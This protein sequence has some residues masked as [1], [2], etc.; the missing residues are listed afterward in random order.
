MHEGMR[1]GSVIHSARSVGGGAGPRV[2]TAPQR[3]PRRRDRRAAEI[4]AHVPAAHGRIV[5]TLPLRTVVAGRDGTADA[6]GVQRG[7]LQ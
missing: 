3:S 4:A 5:H 7:A 6:C 2:T 1:T